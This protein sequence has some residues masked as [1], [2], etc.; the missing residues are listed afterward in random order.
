MDIKSNMEINL[1]APETKSQIVAREIEQKIFTGKLPPNSRLP[2]M[3]AIAKNFSTSLKVVQLAFEILEKKGIVT[4]KL[5]NGTFVNNNIHIKRESKEDRTIYFLIPHSIHT[6]LQLEPSLIKRRIIYG[7]SYAKEK[8]L[9][10]TVA[11]S[12]S[13]KKHLEDIDWHTM[14]QLPEEANVFVYGFWFRKLFPFLL[15]KHAKVIIRSNQSQDIEYPEYAK[16]AQEGNWYQFI[17]DRIAAIEDVIHYLHNYGHQRIGVIKPYINEPMHPYRL[18]MISGY[19]SCGIEFDES[20]YHE[21]DINKNISLENEVTEFWKKTKFDSLIVGN[22]DMIKPVYETLVKLGLRI[23]DDVAVIS[24]TDHADYVNNEVP[25]SAVDFSWVSM[26]RE[27]VKC[28]N[29]DKFTAGQTVFQASI[30]ER[31]S[32]RKGAGA[33]INHNFLP[34]IP[35]N[36]HIFY[37]MEV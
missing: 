10:H 15:E 37:Q 28:F 2:G 7:V 13:L 17:I 33:F 18:G 16:Y 27:M 5:G 24:F 23:P 29:R 14:E 6:T 36:K 4:C 9:L 25:I 35:K 32:T 31:E 3:R 26:G 19:K 21:I 1:K 8:N 12:R 20:L 11:V 22:A 34:E 30:I